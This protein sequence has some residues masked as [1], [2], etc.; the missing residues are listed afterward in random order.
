MEKILA[1]KINDRFLSSQ[2][3]LL[4]ERKKKLAELRQIHR[5]F[6]RLEIE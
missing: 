2:N 3:L 5:P 6:D 4:D 1:E